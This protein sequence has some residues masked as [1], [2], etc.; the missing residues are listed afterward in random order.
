MIQFYTELSRPA[1]GPAQAGAAPW[2]GLGGQTE[3]QSADCGSQAA[4]LQQPQA[5][6]SAI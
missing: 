3:N 2:K 5:A 1:S 4:K 6:G